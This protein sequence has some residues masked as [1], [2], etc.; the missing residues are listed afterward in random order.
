V[1]HG[2]LDLSPITDEP[3][4]VDVL[5]ELDDRRREMMTLREATHTQEGMKQWQAACDAEAIAEKDAIAR[6]RAQSDV[7]TAKLLMASFA[8][9]IRDGDKLSP[10]ARRFL[11][12]AI[13]KMV[14]NPRK[15]AHAYGLV[16]PHGKIASYEQKSADI[17]LAI[18]VR[19]LVLQGFNVRSG[20]DSAFAIVSEESGASESSVR[21]AYTKYKGYADFILSSEAG[22]NERNQS[23]ENETP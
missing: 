2:P 8:C 10:T 3:S 11:F 5:A 12:D 21:D 4:L 1:G 6:A 16:G 13:L 15:A 9:K 20:I 14:L 18:A 22:A 7:E 23:D 17:T 19:R